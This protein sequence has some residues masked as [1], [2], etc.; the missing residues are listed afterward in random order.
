MTIYSLIL[1]ALL[2]PAQRWTARISGHILDRD[3]KPLVNAQVT[4]TNIGQYT[5]GGA[6]YTGPMTGSDPAKAGITYPGTGRVY[7]VRTDKKGE[8]D[9]IGVDFGIYAIEITD[10][11]GKRVYSGKRLVGDNADPNVSNVLNLDLS[12]TLPGQPQPAL[13]EGEAANAS[14]INRLTDELHNALDSRDW[15]LAGSIL[16]QLIA[17]D[18]NRWEFYQNLGAIE[19]NLS[20]YHEAVQ[21]FQKGVEVAEKTLANAPNQTQAK[22]DISGM[23]V[24]EGDAYLRLDKLEAALA[25]YNQAAAIAP[26][27]AMAHFHACNAQ[28]NRGTPAAAIEACK[29]AIAADPDRWE[30][31]QVLGGVEKSAGQSADALATYERGVQ[32]AR[33]E[34]A[35]GAGS[36]R[37]T[38]ALGQMLNAAGDLYSKSARYD[39]AIEAFT[40]S[41][42]LSAYAALP[43]F[44]LCITNYNV[45]R[46]ED[47]LAA[48]DQAI[49]SDPTMAEAY[50]IKASALFRQGTAAQGRYTFPPETRTTLNKYLGFAPFGEHAQAAR[51]ML[52]KLD[53]DEG[54]KPRKPAAK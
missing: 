10:S 41:A 32:A 52:D 46:L 26:S 9:L 5:N 48:C 25:L 1:L 34:I 50:Y 8:F 44:N 31:Y 21:A 13:D 11:S 14:K 2:L 27:P 12:K 38:N 28:A 16:Q 18:P 29:R 45:K 15:R 54:S 43:Y 39:E 19:N 20:H 22:T 37:V 7:K 53:A 33:K 24:S 30:P 42:K 6:M 36:A 51:E 40:E 47:A 23:M 35:P 3:G 49:T 17:L 4:Y